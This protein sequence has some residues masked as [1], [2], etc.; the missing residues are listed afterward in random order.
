[1]LY[2]RS[3]GLFIL[4]DVSSYLKNFFSRFNSLF[5]R[6]SFLVTTN[7]LL[8]IFLPQPWQKRLQVLSLF[9]TLPG[10]PL[11]NPL[12]SVVVVVKR[13]KHIPGFEGQLLH[14]KQT[15]AKYF[16]SPVIRSSVFLYLFEHFVQ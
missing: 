5:K 10:F 15:F 14:I 12:C 11:S 13:S 1:M 4:C 8:L 2:S 3:L 16:V 9:I 6:F 7:F